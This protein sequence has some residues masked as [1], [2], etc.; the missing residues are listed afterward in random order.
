MK[1]PTKLN[2]I[3]LNRFKSDQ[4]KEK[5]H[6]NRNWIICCP[7]LCKVIARVEFDHHHLLLLRL[8]KTKK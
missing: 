3:K 5:P 7:H 8:I 4:E 1:F 6:D 2:Y